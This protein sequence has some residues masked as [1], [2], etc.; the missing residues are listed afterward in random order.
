[1]NFNGVI[2]FVKYTLTLTAACFV[3]SLDK[4]APSVPTE[5]GLVFSLLGVFVGAGLAG[6]FIFAA[7]TAALHAN[8]NTKLLEKNVEF[9]GY[10]HVGL[11]SIGLIFLTITVSYRMV[12]QPPKPSP[13]YCEPAPAT[14]TAK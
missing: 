14:T 1:M 2:E 12:N 10:A 4:L 13:V 3:Y 8:K 6:I 9:A 11:L 7:S 5:P